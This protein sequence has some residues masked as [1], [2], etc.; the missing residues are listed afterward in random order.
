MTHGPTSSKHKSTDNFECQCR[1]HYNNSC[2]GMHIQGDVC[3][4]EALTLAGDDARVWIGHDTR[5]SCR[6]LVTAACQGVEAVGG[7]AEVKGLLT[8][9][10]LHWMIRQENKGLP[11]AESD[12]YKALAE[13]YRSTAGREASPQVKWTPFLTTR[14]LPK[15]QAGETILERDPGIREARLEDA[16]DAWKDPSMKLAISCAKSE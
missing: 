7:K 10:Q 8:T 3:I 16:V 6:E 13:A 4:A 11:S 9:P 14:H 1:P 5:P 12:Y 2:F 15:L